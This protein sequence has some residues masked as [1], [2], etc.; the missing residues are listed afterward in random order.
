MSTGD[1]DTK[2]VIVGQTPPPWHGQA[3]ATQMLFDHVWEGFRVSCIRMAYSS[4]M[5][6]IGRVRWDKVKHLFDL[7][8]R[9]RAELAGAPGAILLYPPASPHWIPFL[10]DVIYLVA[11]RRWASQTVFLY[12]AGGLAEWVGK[13]LLRR[14]LARL[15]YF[16]ADLS[17]EVAVEEVAPHRVF[18]ARRWKWSPYGVDVPEVER[19]PRDGRRP[20]QVL[21]VGS[22]QE[23]KGVLEIL[24]TAA[25]LKGRGR[26][27]DFRFR[28]VGPW[29][30]PAFEDE[31]L[32][33]ADELEV[34]AMVAFPG[35]R[36]G[37]EKWDEYA[38]ADLFF[39][40][41]H[42]ASEAFP[43]VLIEALGSGLPVV[44]TRWRGVPS[45]VEGSGVAT[46][47]EPRSPADFADAIEHWDRLGGDA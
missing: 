31:A 32:R 18:S 27:G 4:E 8:R 37:R 40:P 47:C 29:F 33:L 43:I 6:E 35:Q 36:T 3:V 25:L 39:F 19:R 30:S 45:L 46:L 22:L 24:R 12:H 42:Y 2:L 21:F 10:R 44:T 16:R 9:T 34:G 11:T 13:S 20:C 5:D 15:A 14:L 17:L 26:G 28:I 1:P 23:G 38:A 7:I 41:T